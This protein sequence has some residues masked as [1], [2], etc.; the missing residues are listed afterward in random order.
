MAHTKQEKQSQKDKLT[1][2][3]PTDRPPQENPKTKT[4]KQTKNKKWAFDRN[5][6][7]KIPDPDSIQL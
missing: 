2:V 3:G 4:N 1:S 5:F 6:L 7:D